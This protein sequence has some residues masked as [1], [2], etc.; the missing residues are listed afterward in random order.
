[1][2][3]EG[4]VQKKEMPV[5]SLSQRLEA[6]GPERLKV[7]DAGAVLESWGTVRVAVS[8]VLSGL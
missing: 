8:N 6:G 3:R 1:M 2:T 7:R 5:A 4:C